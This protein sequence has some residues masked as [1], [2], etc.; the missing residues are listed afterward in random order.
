MI[1]EFINAL[2][3]LTIFPLPD[4]P[5]KSLHQTA[6][7]F[8]L[9]GLFIGVILSLINIA[10]NWIFLSPFCS[11]VITLAWIGLTG[12]LH[13]DGLGDCCDAFLVPLPIAQRLNIMKDPHMG[14]FGIV[15]ILLAILLKWAG[16]ASLATG[17]SII[18]WP[19]L[20]TNRLSITYALLL[21]PVLGRWMV[22]FLALP[23]CARMDGMGQEF[24]HGVNLKILSLAGIIPLIMVLLGGIQAV[25]ALLIAF[26]AIQIIIRIANRKIG[27]VTGDVMGMSIEISEIAV[28]AVYSVRWFS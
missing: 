19:G 8:P 27:G 15:G 26:I 7:W 13:L 11:V 10:A 9:V 24:S 28:L 4:T 20:W 21:A 18:G 25:V 17:H 22:L 5:V 23:K 14:T 3:F 12:G 1:V 16:I 2:R 6:P